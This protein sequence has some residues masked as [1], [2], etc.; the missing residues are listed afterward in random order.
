M[1]R[2]IRRL[3]SLSRVECRL[4]VRPTPSFDI[5]PIIRQVADGDGAVGGRDDTVKIE[6]DF[7]DASG[8]R[9]RSTRNDAA[10]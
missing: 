5:V 7:R 3:L 8:N 4:I 9:R 2:V 6:I 10:V 1:A